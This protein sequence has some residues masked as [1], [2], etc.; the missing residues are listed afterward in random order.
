MTGDFQFAKQTTNCGFAS[1][2]ATSILTSGQYN[3]K[4]RESG[5]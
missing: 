2:W 1:D 5:S 4:T 3:A